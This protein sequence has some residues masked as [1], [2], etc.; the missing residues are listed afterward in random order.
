EAEA[1]LRKAIQLRPDLVEAHYALG[2]LLMMQGKLD[3]AIAAFRRCIELNPNAAEAHINLGGA[4]RRQG[5]F[6]E[7]LAAY[8]RGHQRG[9]GATLDEDERAHHRKQALDWLHADLK[10]RE[11]QIEGADR[12]R[13]AEARQALRAW[14]R[15]P[16]LATTRDAAALAKADAAEREA[17]HKFWGE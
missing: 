15:E 12:R 3:D 16:T 9:D 11:K 1:L 2:N 13:R 6:A 4:L 14:Q 7:S 8:R 17:W 10:A 5:Q